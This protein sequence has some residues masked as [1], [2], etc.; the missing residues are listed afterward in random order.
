MKEAPFFVPSNQRCL[1]CSPNNMAYL[2][3]TSLA[4]VESQTSIAA[5]EPLSNGIASERDLSVALRV[6]LEKVATC[7]RVCVWPKWV[8]TRG[9]CFSGIQRYGR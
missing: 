5:K 9:S 3:R 7:T 4:V 6:R 1:P 2:G 8:L